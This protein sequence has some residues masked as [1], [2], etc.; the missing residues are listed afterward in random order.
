MHELIALGAG[1]DRDAGGEL[2]LT[3]EGG[4]LRNR[5]IHAGGDATGAEVQRA[6]VAAVRAD[7]NIEVVENALVLDLL[8]TAEGRA[9]GITL[10]VLG[11][12]QPRRRRG[13]AGPGGG[14]GQRRP[15]TGLRLDHEPA[16]Q[17]R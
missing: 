4:H 15:R 7:E 6:L 3:R 17:H 12:G 16:G 8:L 2:S 14:A 9:A 5:I 11:E 13:G 10:H 1:F